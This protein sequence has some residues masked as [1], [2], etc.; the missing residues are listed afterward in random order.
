MFPE[1]RR[2]V[3][4]PVVPLFLLPPPC[5]PATSSPAHLSVSPGFYGGRQTSPALQEAALGAQQTHKYNRGYSLVASSP[6]PY[7]SL[8]RVT[9]RPRVLPARCAMLHPVAVGLSVSRVSTLLF[10]C[11]PFVGRKRRVGE[12]SAGC[13]V[14]CVSRRHCS[15][16]VAEGHELPGRPA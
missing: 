3:P 16:S 13:S 9:T 14:R 6:P 5:T 4:R 1:Q 2:C 15:V 10:A 12:S 7:T 11:I 8:Q